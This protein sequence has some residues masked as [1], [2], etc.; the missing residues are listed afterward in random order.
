MLQAERALMPWRYSNHSISPT[1]PSSLED[2]KVL[3]ILFH[4][5]PRLQVSTLSWVALVTGLSHH[6]L[7][8][9]NVGLSWNSPNI[10]CHAVLVKRWSP[11][12]SCPLL[13][14]FGTQLGPPLT[15]TSAVL[16]FLTLL[17]FSPLHLLFSEMPKSLFFSSNAMWKQGQSALCLLPW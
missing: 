9:R 13:L 15:L 3:T 4:L 2:K 6:L 12:Q 11:L 1:C 10:T 14:C 5:W 8:S 17:C 16:L 7:H